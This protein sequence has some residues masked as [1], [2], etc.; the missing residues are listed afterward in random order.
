MPPWRRLANC[1]DAFRLQ[2]CRISRPIRRR[3]HGSGSTFQSIVCAIATFLFRS[4][5]HFSCVSTELSLCQIPEQ[6]ELINWLCLV[7]APSASPLASYGAL[8]HVPPPLDVQECIFSSSVWAVQ[9]LIIAY[10]ASRILGQQYCRPGD[11]P[12]TK[13]CRRRHWLAQSLA[14]SWRRKQL[15]EYRLPTRRRFFCFFCFWCFW[16]KMVCSLWRLIIDNGSS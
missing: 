15:S 8:G 3:L 12:R 7:L 13:S 4:Q 16:G 14:A 9:S 5:R 1:A 11:P 6:L 10:P 2:R